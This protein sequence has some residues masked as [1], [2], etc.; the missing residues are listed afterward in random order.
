M[1]IVNTIKGTENQLCGFTSSQPI[2]Y[3][4]PIN[5]NLTDYYSHMSY[6]Y[7]S[8]W[9]LLCRYILKLKFNPRTI[10]KSSFSG[11][12]SKPFNCFIGSQEP[13]VDYFSSY[14]NRTIRIWDKSNSRR[15]SLREKVWLIMSPEKPN[16]G[17][18]SDVRVTDLV[19]S[20][21]ITVNYRILKVKILSRTPQNVKSVMQH[22]NM[23]KSLPASKL[24]PTQ[25]KNVFI[26]TLTHS[27]KSLRLNTSFFIST[28]TVL[29]MI[30]TNC[31]CYQSYSSHCSRDGYVILT[32]TYYI[33]MELRALE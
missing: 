15:S 2:R 7:Y 18:S 5:S 31:I 8:L 28:V 20:N 9:F 29:G 12:C 4:N 32:L 13:N 21:I 14:Y 11:C 17:S 24:D 33:F 27:T 19:H 6:P 25:R 30:F 16:R 26:T 1:S 22:N 10:L 23:K 3:R